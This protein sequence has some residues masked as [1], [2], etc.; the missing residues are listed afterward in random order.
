MANVWLG[1]LQQL[2][3]LP[4]CNRNENRNQYNVN[5][6]MYDE[7]QFRSRFRL[8][9]DGFREILNIIEEDI[10]AHNERGNQ[11]PAGIKLL[12]ALRYYAL[13][14]FSKHVQT[15]VTYLNRL[16]VALLSKYLKPLPD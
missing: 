15:Y 16:Q 8:T 2:D 11:I 4:G 1:R 3:D 9:K 5:D 6:K 14:R 12:L 7:E 13:V 10:S